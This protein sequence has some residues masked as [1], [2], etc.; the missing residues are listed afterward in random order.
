MSRERVGARTSRVLE[1][2]SARPDISWLVLW[3]AG[4]G[5]LL[6]WDLF[7]LNAPA[8]DRFINALAN[9]ML[10]GFLVVAFSLL[11]G[12]L[13]GI[14]LF[15]TERRGLR[16]GYLLGSFLL[17]L[18][19][20]VPQIVGMLAGYVVL[21]LFI[22]RNSGLNASTILCWMSLITTCVV[23]YD[24]TDLIRSRIAQ[25]A[26]LDFYPAM[27][28]SGV[29]ESRIINIEILW[30]N[31]RAHLL[32]VMIGV[33][34]MAVFLQC[35]IDFVLSVGLSTDV[36]ATNFPVTL[37]SLLATMDS[38]QDILAIGTVMTSP[39]YLPQL[40]TTH[41]QGVSVASAIT[42]TLLCIHNIGNGFV[43]RHRL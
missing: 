24:V 33:F 29:R 5:I 11:L 6:L 35:S 8:L 34:G 32:Q 2:A 39:G 17:N 22:E 19:R 18:V 16:T 9:T 27:L 14:W 37:G 1:I 20:S 43:R 31:S 30:K 26:A 12:W 13:S 23:F 21:T 7:F 42:F 28:C 38:K 3:I 41:L 15:M 36:S 4:L 10:A 25:F 40:F